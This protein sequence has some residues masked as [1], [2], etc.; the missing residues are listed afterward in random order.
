MNTN[1]D[2]PQLQRCK[3][4]ELL[5]LAGTLAIWKANYCQTNFSGC[6]R[7][8]LTLL[9]RPVPPNLLPTGALLRSQAGAR[10]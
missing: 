1:T 4:Y 7:F 3:L 6:E 5:R 10:R 2:C 9:G 8:K